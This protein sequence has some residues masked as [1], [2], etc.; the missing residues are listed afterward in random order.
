MQIIPLP[1]SLC[2]NF[3]YGDN[4]TEDTLYTFRGEFELCAMPLPPQHTPYALYTL[5]SIDLWK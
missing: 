2:Q 5:I 1:Y 4:M 3:I